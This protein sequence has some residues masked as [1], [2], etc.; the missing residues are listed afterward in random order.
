MDSVGIS[1][2]FIIFDNLFNM[3]C[4]TFHRFEFPLFFKI[5]AYHF[6]RVLTILVAK[7]DHIG[8]I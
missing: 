1:S 3:S 2:I 5:E 4:L 6:L 7:L 8:P